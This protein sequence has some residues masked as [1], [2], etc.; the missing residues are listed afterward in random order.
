MQVKRWFV[1]TS[2]VCSM[3][4][5][6]VHKIKFLIS[7]IKDPWPAVR[8]AAVC[9]QFAT[10]VHITLLALQFYPP[11]HLLIALANI[12]VGRVNAPYK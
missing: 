12:I 6:V 2:T 9:R 1:P 4:R 7:T 11:S 5:I 10:P 3:A 8:S